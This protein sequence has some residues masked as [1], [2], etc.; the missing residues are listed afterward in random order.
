MM[1]LLSATA[2]AHK[3]TAWGQFVEI[4]SKPDNM[5][6]AGALIL[7]VVFTWVAMRQALAHD[8][9]IKQGKKDEIIEEMQR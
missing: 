6:V 2:G 4:I 8:R 3:L 9:L 5:P 1:T 7:V